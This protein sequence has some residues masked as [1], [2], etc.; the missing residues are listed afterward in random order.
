MRDDKIRER[1]DLPSMNT[2][3]HVLFE[4]YSGKTILKILL[5]RKWLILLR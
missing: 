3:C 1:V 5:I 4:I 2:P